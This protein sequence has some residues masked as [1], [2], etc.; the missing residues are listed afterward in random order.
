MRV[1]SFGCEFGM[2]TEVQGVWHRLR[3]NIE[4]EFDDDDQTPEKIAEIKE[5][6]WNTV[7]NEVE[8]KFEQ[9]LQA[10]GI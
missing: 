10:R 3:A 7:I 8:T 9:A 6:A 2:S 1:T 5:K 4:V